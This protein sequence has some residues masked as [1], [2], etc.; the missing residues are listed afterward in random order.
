MPDIFNGEVGISGN[1]TVKG[2]INGVMLGTSASA[3]SATQTFS[4]EDAPESVSD[5]LSGLSAVPFYKPAP[6][7]AY[8]ASVEEGDTVTDERIVT[9]IEMQDMA[10]A[11]YA[12]SAEQLEEIFPDLVYDNEDGSKGINYIEM[13]PLLVQSVGELNAKIARLENENVNLRKA[14]KANEVTGVDSASVVCVASL[15]QNDPNPF[16][17]STYIRMN[18]PTEAKNAVLCIYD[19][20]GKQLKQ[21]VVTERGG[22]SVSVT[23]EGLCAGMYLYSLIVDGKLVKTRRMVVAS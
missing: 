18:I 20:N 17:Y 22:T 13:I 7:S 11:H 8:T 12:L 21:I 10:K 16:D 5:R 1:L 15:A 9:K 3:L 6:V 19:L 2:T 4:V 23:N 14:A